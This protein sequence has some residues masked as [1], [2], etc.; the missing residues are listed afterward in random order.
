MR[1]KLMQRL[2]AQAE[3]ANIQGWEK[4]ADRL[5]N[6]ISKTGEVISDE[7]Y[8]YASDQYA[9]DMESLFWDGAIK[10][11]NY[12]GANF[13]AITLQPLIESYARE[14]SETLKNK[15]G[16]LSTIGAF[17]EP[18]LGEENVKK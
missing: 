13:D 1:K 2:I 11:A 8:V 3:E 14:F 6:Q 16:K 7:K 17:E 18:L 5:T 4:L 10:T 9:E 15:F 12:Y